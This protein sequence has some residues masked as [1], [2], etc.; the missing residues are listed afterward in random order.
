MGP[1][2]GAGEDL[3]GAGTALDAGLHPKTSVPAAQA[4]KATA[5]ISEDPAAELWNA[6]QLAR[7]RLTI[8]I[9]FTALF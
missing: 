7:A 9:S 3:K 5:A 4:A 6:G 2:E 1:P 8:L